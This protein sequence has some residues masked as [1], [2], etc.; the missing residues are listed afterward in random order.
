MGKSLFLKQW[1]QETKTVPGDYSQKKGLSPTG[2]RGQA[3]S[4]LLTE[5]EAAIKKRSQQPECRLDY[6]IACS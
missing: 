3:D 4:S 2:R 6:I 5:T 1:L